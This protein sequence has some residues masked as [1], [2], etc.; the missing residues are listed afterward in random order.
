MLR[1][2]QW[3]ERIGRHLLQGI[4][5]GCVLL[6]GLMILGLLLKSWPLLQEQDLWSMLVSRDWRPHRGEFGYFPFL[7][8]TLWVTGGA[9]LLA[10]PLALLTATYLSEYASRRVCTLFKPL[11]DLLAGI[12]SV[13]YGVWGVLTIVPL[14]KNEVAPWFGRF[15]SGYCVLS[16][17]LVLA[18]MTLPVIIHVSL[19][20]MQAVP[21]EL[22]ESALSLGAT[23]WQTVKKVVLRKAL[24]GLLA[25]NVLGFARAFGETMAVIMVAGNV[26]R[27]PGSIFDPAYPLPAL[28]A[29]NYGEMMSVPRYDAALML[30]ALLLL[31]VVLGFSVLSRLVLRR[32]QRRWR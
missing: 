22:R 26:A 10:V 4:T 14:V 16:A 19:E 32:L 5:L 9:M 28:I 31:G 21:R 25:A 13:V 17:S 23:R 2:R 7:A 3:Q 11:I 24:P 12:P 8:G 20:V 18:V 30:A 1:W 29:N 15:T 6:A 27:V